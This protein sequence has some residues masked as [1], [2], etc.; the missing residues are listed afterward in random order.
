MMPKV[1]RRWQVVFFA[2]LAAVLLVLTVIRAA[3]GSTG[4]TVLGGLLCF[5]CVMQAIGV[6]NGKPARRTQLPDTAAFSEWIRTRRARGDE[7]V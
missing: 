6:A 1:P 5:D 3:G 2:V 7:R 4:F